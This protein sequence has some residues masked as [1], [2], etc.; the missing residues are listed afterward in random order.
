MC[1]SVSL[2]AQMFLGIRA[3][4]VFLPAKCNPTAALRRAGWR[5]VPDQ[6]IFP[7]AKPHYKHGPFS[8]PGVGLNWARTVRYEGFAEVV[9]ENLQALDTKM[10]LL[11][12]LKMPIYMTSDWCS[13]A[14]PRI[15]SKWATM[16]DF[17][18]ASVGPGFH[19]DWKPHSS[20]TAF[21]F[22][23]QV[24]LC[25]FLLTTVPALHLSLGAIASVCCVIKY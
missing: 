16:R 1:L 4:L 9:S 21:C 19:W 14:L 7:F 24:L 15:W 18:R 11:M 6:G 8:W 17:A 5:T 12:G 22:L 13:W 3:S 20:T 23:P 25:P 2:L 10:S